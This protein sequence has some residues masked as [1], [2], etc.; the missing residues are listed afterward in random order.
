MPSNSYSSLAYS[1]SSPSSG[2]LD[3]NFKKINCQPLDE[4]KNYGFGNFMTKSALHSSQDYV[5]IDS[6]TDA[7][8]ENVI[9]GFIVPK[10]QHIRSRGGRKCWDPSLTK[11]P[12]YTTIGK[13]RKNK[14]FWIIQQHETN[15]TNQKLET[16]TKPH[17][18]LNSEYIR[19][20]TEFGL[21]AFVSGLICTDPEIRNL[22]D[23]WKKGTLLVYKLRACSHIQSFY[24]SPL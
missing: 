23:F 10:L 7:D 2:T 13:S 4:A 17:P 3:R 21:M 11:F 15:C 14:I 18:K 1:K 16:M 20:I 12:F 5:N 19:R 8:D 24:F 6:G 9:K 22:L